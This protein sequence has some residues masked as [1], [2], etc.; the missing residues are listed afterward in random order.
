[1]QTVH[2]ISKQTGVSI[3]AL[4]YYDSIGL[5]RP[6]RVSESGYRLY[7]D[8]ALARLQ[9]ILLFKALGFPLKE[10]RRILESPNFRPDQAL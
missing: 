2:E 9:T 8:S 3:L 10:I 7:D 6:S 5:L 4:H 1:M